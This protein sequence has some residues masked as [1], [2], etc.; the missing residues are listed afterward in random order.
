M[1][2]NNTEV[3]SL[4]S[5]IVPIYNQERYLE[6]C[7]KS[8]LHQTYPYLEII[9]VN[10][11]SKD[12]SGAICKKFARQDRRVRVLEIKENLSAGNG[13]NT[14]LDAAAGE[15]ISFVDGD[16]WVRPEFIEKLLRALLEKRRPH[17][18]VLL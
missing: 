10:N 4:V 7:V 8:L 13:R 1:R 9:L 5:V 6:Q 2:I 11:G 3:T 15:Y 12:R 17:R 18:A 16:D 14:G